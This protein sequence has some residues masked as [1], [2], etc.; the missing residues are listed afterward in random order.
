[1]LIFT[2]IVALI[3][4]VISGTFVIRYQ[5]TRGSILMDSDLSGPQKFH[6]TPTPRVGGASVLLGVFIAWIVSMFSGLVV[7][8]EQGTLLMAAMPVFLAGLLED[9]TKRTSPLVRLLAAFASALLAI[10]LLDVYLPRLGLPVIDVLMATFPLFAILLTIFAVGGVC[11]AINIIDGYNGLMGGVSLLILGA[12]AY[13]AFKVGDQDVLF[14]CVGLAGAVSGFLVW[15]FPRG[16]IFAG[17][18]GAYFIGFLLAELSVLLV[19]KHPGV[20]S[21]WFPMLLMIY[22]VFETI[23]TIYRR[24]RRKAVAVLPDSMHFHQI[25][26]KRLVR[27]M[28]GSSEVKHLVDRNSLTAPYLWGVGMFSV[29]P[30]MLLWRYEWALQ[31]GCLLFT[32]L[33]LWLYHRI[34]HFRSPRWMVLHRSKKR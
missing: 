24:R 13:V 10:L 33:Y 9:V 16:L 27:W 23:F 12:L 7:V 21:P 3:V 5:Y 6:V 4:S 25:I 28:V 17:D 18:A 31:L 11:H 20:V 14:A 34:V 8:H 22:P 26:Y 19:F 30:A 1:M 29:V 32:V 15:N 2:F